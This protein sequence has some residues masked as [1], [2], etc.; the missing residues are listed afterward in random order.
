MKKLIG[1]IVFL[2]ML[3]AALLLADPSARGV[4]NH[5]NLAR[6]IG[7]FGILSL[8]VTP[9]IIT[10]GI[11]LSIGAVM[12]LCTMVLAILLGKPGW[13]PH[14]AV[15][16]VLGLGAGIGLVN[17]LLITKVRLQPFIVTLC[18][19]FLYRGI[20][21]WISDDHIIGLEDSK[22]FDAYIETLHEGVFF[23][24]PKVFVI[25]LALAA[26]LAIILHFSVYGRYWLAIGANEKT[27][28]YSGIRVDRY[29]IFAYIYCSLMTAIFSIL[30]FAEQNSAGSPSSTGNFYELYAI[31]G[32]VLG[33]VSLRGGD[34]NV[35]GVIIGTTILWILPNFARMW[36]IPDTLEF[37]VIGA[38]LLIGAVVDEV[39]RRRVSK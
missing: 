30:Y 20:S 9:V 14:W 11:D 31:A 8:G 32:A 28:L 12:G 33:G 15:M 29:K 22:V 13:S 21:R 4:D 6:R 23:G 10:G 2:A 38:A 5:K 25:M 1:L 7:L 17:G 18:G 26:V 34:G 37:T 3:Y 19:L 39:L 24:M 16:T 35:L 27:A 36:G